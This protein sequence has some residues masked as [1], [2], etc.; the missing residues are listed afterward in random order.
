MRPLLLAIAAAAAAAASS[1]SVVSASSAGGIYGVDVSTPVSA[2]DA[3]CMV[4]QHNV[5]FIVSRAWHSYGG[6]D[7]SCVETTASALAAGMPRAD[8]Y[9]FPCTSTVLT[10]EMQ[11]AQLLGNLTNN[12]VAYGRIWLDIETN[13]SPG[14][15]WSSSDKAANCAFLSSLIAAFVKAGVKGGV[16]S[17]I[18]MWQ[19]WISD[20]PSGCTAAADAGFPLWYPHYEDPS[21]P[22]FSDFEP[23][24]GWS[25]PAAK[26]YADTNTICGI[27]VDDNWAPVMPPE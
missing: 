17:S 6:F 14:C 3:V 16:Y 1:S 21:N 24:G 20:S 22:S 7:P 13:T 10:A 11:L 9:L 27:G 5:S 26:Q 2:S 8:V 4:K 15:G 25:K 12:K 19:T 18:H 23:F